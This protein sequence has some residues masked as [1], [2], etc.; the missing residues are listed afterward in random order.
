[1]VESFIVLYIFTLCILTCRPTLLSFRPLTKRKCRSRV[2]FSPQELPK[3]KIWRPPCVPFRKMAQKHSFKSCNLKRFFFTTFSWTMWT[4][5][6]YV[7]HDIA[8]VARHM[9]FCD[10]DFR[11]RT[12]VEGCWRLETWRRI[13]HNNHWHWSNYLLFVT[14]CLRKIGFGG[15]CHCCHREDDVD[16]SC[17]ISTSIKWCAQTCYATMRSLKKCHKHS[18]GLHL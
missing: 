9:F 3:K 1:M 12:R 16:W 4:I 11:C 13:N 6:N 17:S 14:P 15:C 10:Q 18:E 2:F 8:V 7:L 5:H